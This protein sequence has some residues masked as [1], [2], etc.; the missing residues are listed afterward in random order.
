[1]KLRDRAALFQF[2]LCIACLAVSILLNGEAYF[3]TIIIPAQVGVGKEYMDN[4]DS[5]ELVSR[6][7]Q[8]VLIDFVGR[9]STHH[10]VGSG[11][12]NPPVSLLTKSIPMNI[13]FWRNGAGGNIAPAMDVDSGR[14]S[15]VHNP[16]VSGKFGGVDLWAVGRNSYVGI[17]F[18]A[19]WASVFVPQVGTLIGSE[20]LLGQPREIPRRLGLLSQFTYS[21]RH[22]SANV[23]GASGEAVGC[24]LDSVCRCEQLLG[25]PRVASVI[26]YR[27]DERYQGKEDNRATENQFH[28]PIWSIFRKMGEVCLYLLAF[29]VWCCGWLGIFMALG[30]KNEGMVFRFG[31]GGISSILAVASLVIVH[32]VYLYEMG[33]FDMKHEY[34]EGPEANERFDKLAT[35]LFRAPKSIA[36]P[37]PK[38]VRKPKKASKD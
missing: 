28:K 36:K 22:P 32:Y 4:E 1:L 21:I 30:I 13:R 35:Q 38:P 33:D 9:A 25:C 6:N 29:G 14:F 5:L 3:T 8:K 24:I 2:L 17:S 19:L 37:V 23:S 12:I 18:S 11:G 20:L 15:E 7:P 34:H 10:K 31:V 16:E 27:N 26:E